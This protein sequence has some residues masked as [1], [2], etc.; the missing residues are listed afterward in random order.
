MK[1]TGLSLIHILNISREDR[2]G[3]MDASLV[4]HFQILYTLPQPTE[5][6]DILE[7]CGIV[8]EMFRLFVDKESRTFEIARVNC[9]Y[10]KYGKEILAI[11]KLSPAKLAPA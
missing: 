2:R 5:L 9:R 10:L 1:L 11:A 4:E 8:K 6:D 7:H 3:E